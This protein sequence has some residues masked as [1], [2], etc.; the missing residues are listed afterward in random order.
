MP[1]SHPKLVPAGLESLIATGLS[2]LQ[3]KVPRFFKQTFPKQVG[4]GRNRT[5]TNGSQGSVRESQN[6]DYPRLHYF[7]SAWARMPI[8]EPAF[9]SYSAQFFQLWSTGCNDRKTRAMA[10]SITWP[11]ADLR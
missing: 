2:S 1:K 3:K 6:L 7:S 10:G 8:L 11:P 4:A 5:T 9:S